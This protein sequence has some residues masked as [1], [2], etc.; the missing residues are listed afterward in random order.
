MKVALVLYP[1][2]TALDVVGPFQ[3]LAA[4]PGVETMLVVHEL[5][6]VADGTA[7]CPRVAP[8]SR[9]TNQPVPH[10]SMGTSSAS[11]RYDEPG[12]CLRRGGGP[13]RPEP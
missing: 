1:G 8:T 7:H 2:F 5:G 12:R 4:A 6:S 11:L 3:V 13:P 10:P 9:S